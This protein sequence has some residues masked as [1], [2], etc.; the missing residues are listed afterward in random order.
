MAED[1]V[2]PSKEQANAPK[3]V[4][5]RAGKQINFQDSGYHGSQPSQISQ[6]SQ[7][8][9]MTEVDERIDFP[10]RG[11]LKTP[12]Q[13]SQV[14][15][16]DTVSAE[17]RTT[18][19]SFQS[20]REEQTTALNLE[21]TVVIAEVTTSQVQLEQ[22]KSKAT[23]NLVQSQIV[24]PTAPVKEA[25]QE[26]L[27]A[28]PLQPEEEHLKQSPS[29]ANDVYDDMQ[30][31]SDGSS[32]MRVPLVRKSSLTF[33]SLPAREPL[34]TKQSI[35]NR[36]S[37]TSH[38]DQSRTSYFSRATGGKS[39]GNAQRE[40]YLD[41]EDEMDVDAP[42]AR[43]ESDADSKMKRMH[44]KTST[45]RLQDQI[46]M[47]GQSQSQAPRPSKSIPNMG[48]LVS[49]PSNLLQQ[50]EPRQ[51]ASPVRADRS[52]A[53]PG[54]F[55]DDEEDDWIGP[56]HT[57][58]GA[59]SIFSPRPALNKGYTADVME[60]IH[61]KNSI[62]EVDFNLPKQRR[63]EQRQRSPLRG[64][65][66]PERPTYTLGHK[67][68]A[69]ASV[70]RSPTKPS[71]LAGSNFPK[72][73]SVS[74]PHH[75]ST[76]E[77]SEADP[78]AQKSP[79]G[80]SFRDSPLKAAKDKVSSILKTSRN[81]FA[82]SA[83]ASAAAK[84]STL[85]PPPSRPGLHEASSL[86][87][88]LHAPTNASSLYP[89][90]EGLNAGE[91][92]PTKNSPSRLA[93][94]GKSGISAEADDK[95]REKEVREAQR[96]DEKLEKMREKESQKAKE[97]SQQE[98]E[99]V[100]AMEKQVL[101]RKEQ[102]RLAKVAQMEAPRVTRSS[103]RKTKAQL[104]A[105]GIAAAAA[106]APNNAGHDVEMADVAAM[107]PPEPPRVAS[108]SQTANH[109][110]Q[111]KRPVKPA[112]EALHATKQAPVVIRVDT[113]SQR[114]PQ[115]NPFH[116]SNAALSSSLQ[117]SLGPAPST[118][119]PTGPHPAIKPKPNTSS[120]RPKASNSSLKSVSSA[121]GKVKALEAAAK[122]K[123]QVCLLLI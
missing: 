81:L 101:A 15:E 92:Q 44:N 91:T 109:R 32:P 13:I 28:L 1:P 118:T 35:G 65:A 29:N 6:V 64:P 87:S 108:T 113:G 22:T 72:P 54:A 62:G 60:G 119:R 89:S 23:D 90:L 50:Q 77:N 27:P 26:I 105:E 42:S 7:M 112:K 106:P 40:I 84:G 10:V 21:D 51:P 103:P 56:P 117:D 43:D 68:S 57:A 58:A 96:M 79:S 33:A 80:R 41:D 39:L 95:R 114:N 17:R 16:M 82:S 73:I 98:Q 38:L 66:A 111:I 30:S 121:T 31:P 61:G 24:Q 11:L 99:R 4:A 75:T 63:D 49:Q 115:R 116:P 86:E 100:A 76:V 48:A 97:F 20:A 3:P 59:P 88:L 52:F 83:A 8:T 122:K 25:L 19:G 47:L 45:Q 107:P 71:D 78:S 104:E 93:M 5:P 12:A 67:K 70:L 46:S 18:E 36:T 94:F 85:S 123:E 74:N 37:R 69:S 102:E 14:M 120:I 9:L 34:S 53:A 55:P 2:Q 110:D